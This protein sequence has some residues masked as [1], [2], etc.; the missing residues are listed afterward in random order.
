MKSDRT[1]P[2]F[3]LIS[4]LIGF[5]IPTA[6]FA[7]N[8]PNTSSRP[9]ATPAAVP[10]N[11]PG[12]ANNYI[13]VWEP[14][15]PSNDPAIISAPARTVKEVKQTTRYF[16]G[17][18]REIQSVEKGI[19]GII[20][21]IATG[22]KDRVSMKIY[23]V[24]GREQLIYLPYVHQATSDGLF[25]TTPFSSQATFLQSAT[26]SPATSGETIFYSQ[27]DFEASPLNR[28]LKSYAPGN[29]WAKSGGNRPV[30][31]QYLLNTVSDSVRIWTIAPGVAIPTSAAG[32][33]YAAGQLEKLVTKDEAGNEIV[34]YKDKSGQ[35]VLKKWQLATTPGTAHVGWL[36]T[37]YVYDITGNL[38]F[39]IPP[40][41]VEA[42]LGS[43]VISAAITHELCFYYQFDE[44]K[45]H[46]VKKVPGAG[47]VHLVYDTRDRLVFLQDSAQR[48]KTPTREWQVM[49]YDGLDRP[50]MSALYASNASRQQIQDSTNNLPATGNPVPNITGYTPVSYTYYDDYSWTGKHAVETADL[51]KPQ[52]GGNAY[53]EFNTAVST[54]T[55]GLETGS[56]LR[57]L[58]APTEKWL[59][60]TVYYNDKGRAIQLIADNASGGKTVSTS[61]YDFSGKLLSRY[62]RHS[63][64]SSTSDPSNTLLTMNRYDATGKIRS[65]KKR[66]N[67]NSATDK[68]IS[69]YNYDES[70]NLRDKRLGVS[71]AATQIE[72]LTHE[73]NIRGWLK[74]INK[75]YAVT[76]GSTANWFGMEL[77]YD[78]GFQTNQYNGN[79]AGVRWKSMGDGVARA[80]G[81]LYDK[82]N[83]LRS[84]DFNQLNTTASTLWEK[85][86]VDFSVSN[87]A[88]DVG[89]NIL[90]MKQMGLKAGVPAVVDQLRYEYY[91]GSNKLRFVRDTA[92][93]VAS[94][95]GDFKEPAAN[96]SSNASAPAT[97]FDYTYNQN[98]SLISDKNKDISAITYNHL[99]QPQLIIITGKGTIA[100]EYDANGI[101]LKKTVTDNTV[102]PAKVSSTVYLPGTIYEN[103]T[104]AFVG[105]EEGRIRAVRKTGQPVAFSYDYFLKDHL[106]NVRMVLTDQTDF[107]MYQASMEPENAAKETALFSNVD[108]SRVDKPVGYPEDEQTK[109]N[110]A[111]AKLNG[112]DPD[113][114]IGPSLV[115]KVMAG[116]TIRI[117]ARAFYKTG[118]GGQPSRTTAPLN[119]MAGALL[120]AFGSGGQKGLA[121]HG[122]ATN[123]SATPFS[124]NFVN[125]SWERL[126]QKENRGNSNPNRPRAYLNFVLF[127][128]Q[129]GM[130]EENSG[131]R[132]VA[133]NPDQL[134]TLAQDNMVVQKSGYLYVYTSNET[135][136]DVYFDNLTVMAISGPLLEETHYYPYGLAMAGISAKAIYKPENKYQYNGKELQN[137]EFSGNG[138]S[139]LEW[140]DYGARMYDPQI[141]RWHHI[142]PK[143]DQMRRW[144]PYNYAFDNPLRF[145]D[146]DGMAPD[147]WV[148]T[149]NSNG[150]YTP[151]YYSSKSFAQKAVEEGG[152]YL[153][154]EATINANDGNT[155]KLNRDGTADVVKPEEKKDE[156]EDKKETKEAKASVT[157]SAGDLEP[158]ETK[159]ASDLN[160]TINIDKSLE[161]IDKVNDGIGLENSV[162]DG[163]IELAKKISPSGLEKIGKFVATVGIVS[164]AVDASIAAAQAFGDPTVGNVAKAVLKVGLLALEVGGKVNP[165]VGIVTGILDMTGAT[166]ALFKL[167]D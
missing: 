131:V 95:L 92:N 86:L 162:K 10:A 104:L 76:A 42:I 35:I 145:I 96:N 79:I 26:L 11:Y 165:A 157:K 147:D 156:K 52:A 38:R 133:A 25:K 6:L 33:T 61:L 117:G 144:S 122:E 138:G 151:R 121:D 47:P 5:V 111:V 53:A 109:K 74:S 41:A 98:G 51:T 58:G 16:D 120:R 100:F 12:T 14:S 20:D 28:V 153:G 73:Y 93:D 2:R 71:G 1:Y 161:I 39:V 126:K 139:G 101:K 3:A 60:S 160:T 66:V 102:T 46:I 67:D 149:K 62:D 107:S 44:R 103:D 59:I 72:K 19:G 64:P 65:V 84:A 105:H 106:G 97:D 4:W 113:R 115:L 94:L 88:Y 56:K 40:K 143:T 112:A 75:S 116:D 82:A 125:N 152:Y 108:A 127:D 49:F 24:F 77:S 36:C 124:N 50:T 135:P 45:R 163:G 83:R 87:L 81:Y 118:P 119:D 132:Q 22:G 166:D 89:G 164:A 13:R 130:V 146:P 134:Q 43:W 142:D 7:Q 68:V 148:A 80:Y 34:E 141:G 55:Q 128:E 32:Q 54:L 99:H 78:Y 155:Y 137:K 159:T 48:A 15:M 85:N 23:D 69:E 27:S 9:V 31:T 123:S 8:A 30:E 37:Y 70:G 129:L 91:A 136:Q 29:S 57:V 150:T 63:N 110:A 158:V 17:L 154:K 114:R 21:T 140:Y 90:S 18:G 167:L